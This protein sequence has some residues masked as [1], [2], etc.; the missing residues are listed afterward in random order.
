M[1]KK[2]QTLENLY[3]YCTRRN[4]EEFDNAL[5]KQIAK[6]SGFANPFDATYI[7]SKNKLPDIY[8]ENDVCIVH[9]G[10]GKHRFIKGIENAYH[11]FEKIEHTIPWQYNKSVINE[12]NTSEAN[13]LSVAFNQRIISKFLYG[14][15]AVTPKIYISHRTQYSFDYRI[16]PVNVKTQ[17]QQIEID[18]TMENNGVLSIFEAKSNFPE[19]FAVYQI[20]L[21]FLYYTEMKK[22]HKL[23]IRGINC[24][25]LLRKQEGDHSKIRIYKYRFQ[26]PYNMASIRLETNC[27]YEIIEN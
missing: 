9:L 10:E 14:D 11:S 16:G 18:M 19:D 2:Q 7:D 3:K 26:E 4:I 15:V 21:P 6:K 17:K 22:K 8:R 12:L 25:Y 23:K 20:Y 27:E 5:V 13:I 24:C 1:S